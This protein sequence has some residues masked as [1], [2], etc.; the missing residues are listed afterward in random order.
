MCHSFSTISSS[1][2]LIHFSHEFCS[3]LLLLVNIDFV[4]PLLCFTLLY[5]ALLNTTL[6][7]VV[8]PTDEVVICFIDPQVNVKK[9]TAKKVP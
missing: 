3:L 4:M 1:F 9:V 5:L 2:L 6:S 7:S 8:F